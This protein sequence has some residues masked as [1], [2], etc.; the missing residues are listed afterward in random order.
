M[1][2]Y[3]PAGLA[4]FGAALWAAMRSKAVS[5]AV[6]GAA[7]SVVKTA[8]AWTGDVKAMQAA[9]N[10]ALRAA[11][12]KGIAVDGKAGAMTCRGAEW[13]VQQ[14]L[15]TEDIKAFAQSKTCG[16]GLPRAP[17]GITGPVASDAVKKAIID[18]GVK[19]GYPASDVSKAV[20]RESGW[21]PSAVACMG[22]DKHPVAGGLLQFI[23]GTLKLVG[24]DGSPDQFASLTAE[25]QLPYL[26]KFIGKMPPS[27]LH[28]P[29]DFGLALFTPG[30]VGKPDDFVIY[31]VG[32][33]GWEQNPGLRTQGGK[34]PIT[35]G[36]VRA[37]AR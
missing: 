1:K 34:G 22:A 2:W 6:E 14:G 4:A 16:G 17:C 12:Q 28:K 36:S 25:Q 13:L 24:F 3:I 9:I 37:T 7:S 10:T 20:S 23:Q 30:Y 15:A 19:K 8:K 18:A 35:A 27:T 21:H 26:L 31:D 32:S 33:L 29:G 5:G 11:G